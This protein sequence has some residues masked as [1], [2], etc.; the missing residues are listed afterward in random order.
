MLL[1]S[2]GMGTRP[3]SFK[4]VWWF[5]KQPRRIPSQSHG[6]WHCFGLDIVSLDL[7]NIAV[8]A[9]VLRRHLKDEELKEKISELNGDNREGGPESPLDHH[10]ASKSQYT[11]Y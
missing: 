11:L 6:S 5:T 2:S 10:Q 1:D 3:F 7:L 9:G 4:R 8:Q